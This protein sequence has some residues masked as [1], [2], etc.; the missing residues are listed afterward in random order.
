MNTR[1][2]INIK[3]AKRLQQKGFT[4]IEMLV[5]VALFAVVMLVSTA[6][7]FSIIG[8]N[9]KAQGIN[10]VSNNLNFAVESMV[11]DIK[12]GY[13]YSCY[14]NNIGSDGS[15]GDQDDFM[16]IPIP[17]PDP[18][19]SNYWNTVGLRCLSSSYYRSITFISTLDEVGAKTVQYKFIAGHNDAGNIYVP[20]K[21]VKITEIQGGSPS[22]PIDVTSPEVDITDVKFFI[23]N[24][25][26][27]MLSANTGGP[28]AEY[29]QPSVFM[30][31]K[32]VAKISD[33]LSSDFSLQTMV[34]QR[35]LNL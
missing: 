6:V 25:K 23:N 2:T 28:S 35:I 3:R 4:L 14:G 9:R 15:D 11:R 17:L 1:D 27:G 16:L 5:A 7:I 29:Q 21:I 34:S 33:N 24:P 32:G 8:G 13:G 30:L 26:P 19:T 20:G 22:E 10:A 18:S 31:I 12:T